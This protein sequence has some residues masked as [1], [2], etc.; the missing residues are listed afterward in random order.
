MMATRLRGDVAVLA[1]S[2]PLSPH[3]TVRMAGAH[4]PP[5]PCGGRSD[6]VLL[7]IDVASEPPHADDFNCHIAYDWQRTLVGSCAR[8]LPDAIETLGHELEMPP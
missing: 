3:I 6:F 5:C 1:D 8:C 4:D 2:Y 7:E